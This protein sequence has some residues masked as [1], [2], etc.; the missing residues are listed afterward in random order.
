VEDLLRNGYD[1]AFSI[2]PH[3]A[4][5][6]HDSSVQASAEDQFKTYVEYGRRLERL[7]QE[8]QASGKKSA[9]APAKR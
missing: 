5:V 3:L 1:A 2:E 4:V 8:I 9:A 6:F 7:I